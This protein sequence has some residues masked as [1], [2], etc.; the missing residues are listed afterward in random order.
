MPLV[1]AICTN[2]AAPLEVDPSKDAAICPYCSTPYIV[3]KA[4]NQYFMNV[5][6]LNAGVVNM[7][8]PDKTEKLFK[9]A[10]A[11]LMLEEFEDALDSYE[12]LSR[13]YAYD[14]RAWSGLLS[15]K[16]HNKTVVDFCVNDV[17]DIIKYYKN[18]KKLDPAA[19]GKWHD[20]CGSVVNALKAKKKKLA[21]MERE[22]KKLGEKIENLEKAGY[23][24]VAGSV[25]FFFVFLFLILP[26]VKGAANLKWTLF[27]LD[28]GVFLA[29]PVMFWRKEVRKD[30]KAKLSARISEYSN[31][32]TRG[33]W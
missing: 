14:P 22:E 9:N 16:S 3:E 11:Q 13:S 33:K 1:K 8:Q 20:Y 7:V 23:I 25:G 27:L 4:I 26:G 5:K 6:T 28:L 10:E 29:S 15:A 31:R 17:E 2:C 18:L 24:M 30:E 32:L 19:A 21:D 12:T